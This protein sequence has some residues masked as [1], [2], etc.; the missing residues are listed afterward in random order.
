MALSW[1]APSDDGGA[2]VSDYEYR[3]AEGTSVPSSD[4]WTALGQTTTGYIRYRL[5]Q[6]DGIHL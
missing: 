5:G 2:T 4:S 3:Y 1:A 6:G